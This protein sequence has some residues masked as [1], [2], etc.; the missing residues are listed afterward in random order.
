[1]SKLSSATLTSLLFSF[2]ITVPSRS[3][4]TAS[5]LLRETDAERFSNCF[6]TTLKL[7]GCLL[8]MPEISDVFEKEDISEKNR[9]LDKSFVKRI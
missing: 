6:E 9:F 8:G 4:S 1:M 2:L 3:I 7:L 5:K